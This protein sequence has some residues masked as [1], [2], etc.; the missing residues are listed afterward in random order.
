MSFFYCC[1]CFIIVVNVIF[2]CPLIILHEFIFS[3]KN[4]SETDL[5]GQLSP[6]KEK[7][8]KKEKKVEEEPPA[9]EGEMGEGGEGG[10]DL[11][12][13]CRDT[14]GFVPKN[15]LKQRNKR[16][17]ASLKSGKKD[18]RSSK[19][20]ERDGYLSRFVGRIFFL[21]FFLF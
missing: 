19:L 16:I 11:Y 18:K 5:R 9:K 10:T 14:I 13:L 20:D 4:A 2:Y 1:R 21:S 7:G 8:E 6:R 3:K 12:A 17:G 15:Y